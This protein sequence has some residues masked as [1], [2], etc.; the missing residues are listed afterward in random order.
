VPPRPILYLIRHGET[1]WNLEGR[2]QGGRDIPLN[3]MGRIQAQ[4]V[5]RRLTLACPRFDDLDYVASPM[6]RARE[7]MEIM[8][9]ELGLHAHTY[10]VDERL[11]EITFGIWEG[12]TWREVRAK[13]P[14]RARARERDKWGYVPPSGESYRMLLERIRPWYDSLE[15]DTA[16]VCH[17]GVARVIMAM[18]A[19][20]D[21]RDAAIAD[22]HQGRV[23]VVR[24]GKMEWV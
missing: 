17:G 8:R 12:L 5:A 22:I 14:D 1:D 18:G 20:M 6:S 16:S 4:D 9:G 3:D 21:P 7:T 13:D 15:R 23:L 11:R 24:D 2:L 10:R 19:G